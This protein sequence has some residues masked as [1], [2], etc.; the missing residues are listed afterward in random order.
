MVGRNVSHVRQ[1]KNKKK[2]FQYR[3]SRERE[4]PEDIDVDGMTALERNF[5]MIGWCGAVS[6][7]PEKGPGVLFCEDCNEHSG[8]TIS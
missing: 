5:G 1:K 2:S 8:S 3:D 7:G 6:F 4:Q